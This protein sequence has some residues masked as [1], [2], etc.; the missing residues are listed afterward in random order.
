M[1]Q[2]TEEQHNM[3]M[4]SMKAFDTQMPCVGIF[5]YDED[6]KS[7]FGVR[8][9]ELTPKMVEEAADKGLPFINYPQL[10]RQVWAKEYF[11]AQAKHLETK[12]LG[13]YTKIPRGR[14]A[15]NI[16]KFIVLVG[17]WAEP[18]QEELSALIEEEFSLPYFELVYDRH[19]D[20]G[21]GWS[22]DMK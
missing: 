19:W 3:Q 5:W 2:L 8:K 16:D 10:H 14:V 12:F 21:H 15:W 20:L 13:D 7:L 4:E 17:K 6:S 22:G 9:K 1:T 18:I 11:K